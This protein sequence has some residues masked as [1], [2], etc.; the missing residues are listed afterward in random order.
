MR[1]A[2]RSRLPTIRKAHARESRTDAGEKAPAAVDY[3]NLKSLVQGVLACEPISFEPTGKVALRFRSPSQEVV[4]DPW[5]GGRIASWK[6]T[7]DE[8]VH[9][10]GVFGLML[11]GFYYPPHSARFVTEPYEIV[12]QQRTPSGIRVVLRRRLEMEV[13]R[14]AGITVTKTLDVASNAPEIGVQTEITNTSGAEVEFSHRYHNMPVQ[15]EL[16]KGQNGW[17]DME[18]H[19][20][21]ARFERIFALQMYRYEPAPRDD[22]LL[23]GFPMD[24]ERIIDRPRIVLGC[25]WQ[26]VK[27]EMNLDAHKLAAVC[28]WDAG[29]QECATLE[30][31]HQRVR[32]RPGETWG[33]RA[34]LKASK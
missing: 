33:V 28:F 20:R 11:D 2:M 29:S 25:E 5:T 21:R 18:N 27:V 23:K 30:P 3:S 7:G 15:L 10:K 22:V 17:A 31:I 4:V 13:N 14:L 9:S 32:L 26:P 8:L 34:I 24:K 16:K 12:S 19:G 6:V 1:A